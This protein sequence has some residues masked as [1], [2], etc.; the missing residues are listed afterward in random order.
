MKKALSVN[1]IL[2]AKFNTLPFDGQWQDAFGQP[3]LSGC[4]VVY[5][6]SKQGKTDFT[7]QFCKYLTR[8]GRVL[9]NSVEEGLSLSIQTAIERNAMWEAGTK[10]IMLDREAIP[11]LTERL[12]RHRS[13]DVVVIDSIQ[14]LEMKFSDYKIFK[15]KFKRKL[16]IYV[17]HVKGGKVDGSVAMKIFRDANATCKIE[18]FRMFPVSRYGGGKYIDISKE[19]AS[20]YWGINEGTNN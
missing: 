15:D 20:E 4:M 1:N 10:F 2:Q 8:F 9:Y 16:F 13:A 19:L 11:E 12:K 5:G 17:S 14:F 3:E 7:L 18:G 6:E